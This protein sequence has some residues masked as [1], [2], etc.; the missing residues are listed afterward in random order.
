MP[1]WLENSRLQGQP[2][3]RSR[4]EGH[5][6]APEDDAGALLRY[7]WLQPGRGQALG[8]RTTD[9]GVFGPS[10]PHRHCQKPECRYC[11]LAP[12]A[13]ASQFQV[14][15]DRVIDRLPSGSRMIAG[16]GVDNEQFSG[17]ASEIK[18]LALELV[19]HIRGMLLRYKNA[20]RV[21]R[22]ESPFATG[23]L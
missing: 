18:Q 9:S 12:A 8:G 19:R 6:K 11:R 7:F 17:T 21:V 1:F 22:S 15:D 23:I 20:G 2:A 10:L 5:Q 3:R 4:C 14:R 13:Q 16:L